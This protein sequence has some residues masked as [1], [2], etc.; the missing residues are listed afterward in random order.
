MQR[1]RAAELNSRDRMSQVIVSYPPTLEP[2]LRRG[3]NP[4][5]MGILV[6][7]VHAGADVK[8]ERQTVLAAGQRKTLRKSTR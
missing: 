7:N 1:W 4:L 8:P 5:E 3:S 2:P 6:V